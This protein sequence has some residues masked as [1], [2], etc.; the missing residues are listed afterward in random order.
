[1]A[2]VGFEP[3]IAW[4]K[5]RCLSPSWLRGH[6]PEFTESHPDVTRGIRLRTNA[7]Y[8]GFEPSLSSV[9]GRRSTVKLITHVQFSELVLGMPGFQLLWSNPGI[10]TGNG[11]RTRSPL[12][13]GQA[14]FQ[15]IYTD[16][17]P[18]GIEPPSQALQASANP[19]Q[20]ENHI[21]AFNVFT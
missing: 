12:L 7:S 8:K 20:L 19:S 6:C 17:V 21:W 15:L 16:V 5:A 9:T 4:L 2:P 18:G 10:R 1:V 13:E 11:A 3:T 14:I